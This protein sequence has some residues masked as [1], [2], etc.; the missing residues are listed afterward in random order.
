MNLQNELISKQD[1][2]DILNAAEDV[3]GYGYSQ[4][5]NGIIEHKPRAIIRDCNG[6]FGASFNDCET[7]DKVQISDKSKKFGLSSTED[8]EN[9]WEGAD[10]DL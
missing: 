8:Y 9:F 3:K 10:D 6:C 5:H 1:A 7:R 4:V 2:I